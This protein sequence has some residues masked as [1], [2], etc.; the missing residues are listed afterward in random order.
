MSLE[1]FLAIGAAFQAELCR[2]PAF[3]QYLEERRQRERR[4]LGL[5]PREEETWTC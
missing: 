2:D 3:A 1:E 4:R 5:A